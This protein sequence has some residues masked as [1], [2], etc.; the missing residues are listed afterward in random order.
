MAYTA[1]NTVA[2][3]ETY[4][5]AAHNVI[6][7]DIIYLKAEVDAFGY[8]LVHEEPLFTNVASASQD[9]VFTSA[10]DNYL[11]A[12][13]YQNLTGGPFLEILLRTGG[14]DV[15]TNG[16]ASSY[17]RIRSDGGALNQSNATASIL[18]AASSSNAGVTGFVAHIFAPAISGSR[19]MITGNSSYSESNT[20]NYQHIIGAHTQATSAYDGITLKASSGNVTGQFW[21]Y[22][23][24]S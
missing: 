2:A 17:Y 10:Y 18:I 12:G 4:S 23:A 21:V 24:N 19:T 15:T 16:Y 22:G 1:P 7:N 8:T 6:V 13:Y 14:S 3:G 9:G 11:L 20:L 5:A